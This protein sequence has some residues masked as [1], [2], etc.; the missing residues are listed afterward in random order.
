MKRFALALMVAMVLPLQAFAVSP[1]FPDV[2]KDHKNFYAVEVLK[3]ASVLG[4]YPDG[5]FKPENGINRAEYATV[6]VNAILGESPDANTYKNCF[7]DVTTEWFAPHICY[8]KEQGWIAGYPDGTFQPVKNV[9][10]A[11]ALLMMFNSTEPESADLVPM[12]EDPFADVSMDQ[13]F[14]KYVNLAKTVQITE[15]SSGNFYPGNDAT[16]GV[17]AEY[18]F[19]KMVVGTTGMVYD[20]ISMGSFLVGANMTWLYSVGAYESPLEIT[21]FMTDPY[22]FGEDAEYIEIRNNGSTPINLSGYYLEGSNLLY[23]NITY[24]FGNVTLGAGES[25]RVYSTSFGMGA[26]LWD[27]YS[28]VTLYDPNDV[29]EYYYGY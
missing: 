17:V 1:T 8:A 25:I 11:E 23:E 9:N 21:T 14:A 28:E 4:G 18:L 13:W 15:E 10:R 16:R 7:P 5:T 2:S 6:L 27:D 19:R 29:V 24:T 26:D 22:Y 20:S 12:T 3:A